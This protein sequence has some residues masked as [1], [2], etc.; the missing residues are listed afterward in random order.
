VPSHPPERLRQKGKFLAAEKF[1]FLH[2]RTVGDTI[3]QGAELS[4]KK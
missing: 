1:A 3:Y 2:K 4:L